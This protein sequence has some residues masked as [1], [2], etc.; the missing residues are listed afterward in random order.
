M[1]DK[2][3]STIEKYGMIEKGD[4]I[5]V[6]LSGGPDSTCLIHALSTIKEL[7]DIRIYAVHLNHMIRAEE[8]LRDEK[9]SENLAKT[10]DIPFFSKQIPVESYASENKISTE[11]AGRFLRYNLF[12]EIARKTGSKKIAL[13]HNMNDQAET[14]LMHLIRGSGLSGISGIRPVR[15][16]KFIRPIIAC[17]R[18]EIEEY[19]SVNNLNPVIDSSNKETIYTRNRVRLELIPYIKKYFNP[20]LVENLYKVSDIIRDEDDYLNSRTFIELNRIKTGDG[21]DINSFNLLHISIKRRMVRVLI[22]GIKG[23]LDGIQS[24]HITE[25]VDFIEKKHTGKT[26]GLPEGIECIIQYDVFKISKKEET[27]DFEYCL[28]VPGNTYIKEC[29]CGVNVKIIKKNDLYFIDSEFIKYFDYDKIKNKMTA[30]NKRD[31]DYIY[32]KGMKGRKK[33]K[34]IFIDKKIPREVRGK[35]L[36]ITQESEVVWIFGL[37]DSRKYK[38]DENTKHVMEIEIKR[39]AE[40]E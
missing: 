29:N 26:L 39:G 40:D 38:V 2:I 17:S 3:I 1:R 24:K 34:D 14:I 4:G 28:K 5:V 30:R 25:C 32:P 21:V 19:C 20:N 35:T 9:Y 23:D 10:L 33:I 31:G 8:A 27:E 15:A 16:G 18:E 13:A 22:E 12:E 37:R 36:L 7:Y 6:G 11:E